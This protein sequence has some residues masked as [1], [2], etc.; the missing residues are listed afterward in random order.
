M[1]HTDIPARLDRL[2]WSRW[3]WRVVIALGVAWVLDGLEVT[4]VG[5]V[6]SVLERP[7]T[8][9][10]TAAQIGGAGSL[11]IGGAVVGALVF[12]RLADKLGRKRLFLAT[13]VVYTLAT[14]ATAFSP[15]FA[16]F[17]VCRFVTGLG[18]GG[19]YAAINS[20]IDEL[21]PARVRGRVN[22]AINGS[23]W[24]GA[25]LGAGVS[26]VLL[27][28]RVL[29]PVWGWRG[30]FALGA[31]LAIAILLVRRDVP[32]SPRWLISH[33]R[34]DE[35]DAIMARIETEVSA[36]HGP[37]PA[38]TTRLSFVQ[39][40][41]PTIRQVAD[42]LFHRYRRRS[43]V[44][45]S[46]MISQAFFYN[47]IFFTYALVL[48]RFHGV[49]EGRVALYIFPFAL[50][51]VLGPLLLGPLF[52]RVGR[53]RMIGATYVL[54]GVG[55]ALTGAAFMAGWLDALSQALCWSAV[56]FLASAAASSAYLTVSEVFPL[57]MRALA[58]S[59]FFAV[60]T[61]AGGFAAPWLFGLLIET[62]S[63]GAVAVGYGI[64]AALVIAA[65]LIAWRYAVDA[66]RRSL[67]D[68][69]PPMGSGG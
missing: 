40:A 25:A 61:G 44:A 42:V 23:F 67:E 36:Q 46:L 17:A 31:L 69:A 58:I 50:G 11:Y 8:L 63:R 52:D 10:L 49:P 7:D 59:V 37:L 4:L 39:Q 51:N 64:G 41:A 12:G 29:G 14:L 53:R 3:H 62:G 24:I 30:G 28:P 45:L 65:G 43:V 48:T 56:F 68:I 32:E 27:D 15:S 57:E 5:S 2:P 22:L 9:G 38:V 1:L 55:L 18:I 19:E 16:F 35:A 6:G 34:A 26:L 60:G 13:L 20:A 47:A 21:I 33:G 54:S 66:E